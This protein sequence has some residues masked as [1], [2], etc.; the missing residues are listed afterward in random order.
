MV[1]VQQNLNGLRDLTTPHTM[2][3]CYP[4]SRTCC[5]QPIY[6]NWSL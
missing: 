5:D 1:G 3:I 2:I 6:Q 4:R